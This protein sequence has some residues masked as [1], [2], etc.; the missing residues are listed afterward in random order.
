MSVDTAWF[1]ANAQFMFYVE[2][3]HKEAQEFCAFCCKAPRATGQGLSERAIIVTATLLC[4]SHLSPAMQQCS[5]PPPNYH[6]KHRSRFPDHAGTSASTPWHSPSLPN[7]SSWRSQNIYAHCL[8]SI[9]SMGHAS[10]ATQEHLPAPPGIL[11]SYRTGR[12]GGRCRCGCCP[13][14]SCP[15]WDPPAR[16]AC[17]APGRSSGP[18]RTSRSL[19]W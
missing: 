2:A 13:P 3:C 9:P 7:W 17:T 15:L 11:L 18:A 5:H 4:I 6:T 19:G 14:G 12:A 16:P 1:L 10:W 8:I